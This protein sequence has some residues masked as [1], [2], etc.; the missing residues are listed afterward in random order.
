MRTAVV[1]PAP[2][3]ENR[4]AFLWQIAV[5]PPCRPADTGPM[6]MRW[7]SIT[8]ASVG[9]LL[10][11]AGPLVGWRAGHLG[12]ASRQLPQTAA[13]LLA[14]ALAALAQ[15][16]HRGARRLLAVGLAMA[17][18]G[19]A[20]SAYSAF[21][22]HHPVPAWGSAAILGLDLLDGLQA[23]AVLA[24]LAVFPDGAYHRPWERPV[25]LAGCAW[26][27]LAV[28]A[29]RLGSATVA[30]QGTLIWGD[31]VSAPNPTAQPT[32]SA[33]GVGGQVAIQA[34]F[35]LFVVTG[36]VL[37][38][39]RYHRL[40]PDDQRRARWLLAG[41]TVSVSTALILALLGPWV[42]LL[43]DVAVYLLYTPAAFA[44]PAAIAV[45][46]V[47][48]RFLDV[49][50]MIR[51]SMVY[52]VVWVLI[53]AVYVGLALALG[54]TAGG[55]MRLPLALLVTVLATL[56][57]APLRRWLDRWADRLVFG[58]RLSGYEL[59]ASLGALLEQAPGTGG[60]G[61]AVA[62]RVRTG[63]GLRW[64]RVL[65]DEAARPVAGT[66]GPVPD[67]PTA[68]ARV[69]LVLGDVTVG[70]IECGPRLRGPLTE[71]DRHV[72]ATL[73]RQ[74]ALAVR[75]SWL[76]DQ[77]ADRVAELDASRA[78]LVHAEDASRRRLERDLHDGVQQELVA[79]LARLGLARN[80][81]RR[82][83]RLSEETLVEAQ[84]DAQRAL[85][86]LQEVSRGIHPPLLTD[87]G[88]AEAV[89]E[90][91]SRLPVRVVVDDRLDPGSRF[92]A[93]LEAAA[94]FLVSEALGNVLKH[95]A[96]TCARIELDHRDGQLLVVVGDDGAGFDV[97]RISPRGL[98][99]LRDRIEALGGTLDVLS[100]L[101]E[102]TTLV[103][104]IPAE[105]RSTAPD[106]VERGREAVHG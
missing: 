32:L 73:G 60:M 19:L 51:R 20:G 46:M 37:L 103:A 24:L 16:R 92:D 4:N 85:L 3:A 48:H 74:A 50:A 76:A 71:A 44:I 95:A 15:P 75:S 14:G 89:A 40:A 98:T 77:L 38:G 9:V 21:L 45:A 96:A 90:R 104:R 99:G 68:V 39:F 43:P 97:R 63:L 41:A 17:S 72:L 52:A 106:A 12:E 83:P 7:R 27:A 69:P 18:G 66:S 82:D 35:G 105:L 54:L 13:F 30:Y 78:R 31:R 94:Y 55:R 34:S 64:A 79:L 6:T 1:A 29:V 80:Q 25:V 58:R 87:R 84:R 100:G 91:A 47:R 70:S 28:T 26:V 33:L 81:L 56:V 88:I 53:T 102:G 8:L 57:V 23:L 5:T 62:E 65:L 2:D 93:D 59:I 11:V 49:D 61:D 42:R 86:S 36:V 67:H 22:L 10:L 101:G